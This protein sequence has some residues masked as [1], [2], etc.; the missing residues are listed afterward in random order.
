M[1]DLNPIRP[2]SGSDPVSWNTPNLIAKAGSALGLG[3]LFGGGDKNN[4]AA[5]VQ[6]W[7]GS[8][9]GSFSGGT[10]F[11][12]VDGGKPIDQLPGYGGAGGSMQAAQYYAGQDFAKM[13]GRNPTQN[14]LTQLSQYYMSGDPNI[15]NR[16]Q[17]QAALS[18]FYTQLSQTPANLY[19]T[20]QA[21]LTA[22]AP[23]FYDSV[24][25]QFQS[26]L[27]R[28]ATDSEKTHFGMLLAS[29]NDPYE[30]DQALQSTPEYQTRATTDFTNRLGTQLQSS[31][32]DYYS[33]YILPTIQSQNAQAGRTQDS[34]GYQAQLANAAQGQNYDLQNYLA[35]VSASQYGQSTA[36]ALNLYNSQ[37]QN[38][39]N[40]GNANIS[41]ALSNANY[42]VQ[43]SNALSDYNMQQQAYA[44]YL[45]NYGKRNGAASGIQGAL[46]GGFMG[47]KMGASAGPWG[48][49]AGGLGGAALGGYSGAYM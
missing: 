10:I 40:L 16:T 28:D 25:Q 21:Q 26:Q 34:S 5:K 39:Q 49:L 45:N 38:T 27:G 19:K 13:F 12:P 14:E 15:S 48:A 20:Q 24:N 29:G 44:N 9:L 2:L 1:V 37:Y 43:R 23:K 41:N 36:N 42:N 22:Q 3:G 8:D 11:D 47:A 33:K 35:S 17:G 18:N 6:A 7:A 32:A 31:N 4:A 30:I 46:S